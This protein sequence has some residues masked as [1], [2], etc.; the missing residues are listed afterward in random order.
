MRSVRIRDGLAL[1]LAAAVLTTRAAAAQEP[2][3]V[4]VEVAPEQVEVG[5]PV[6][7]RVTVL[8]PTWFPRPPEY[9]SLELANAVTRLDRSYP[10]S[11]RVG[12]N[13]SSA[14]SPRKAIMATWSRRM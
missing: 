14:V 8:T 5:R 11:E 2:P 9:P 12:G 7:L 6:E 3:L 4:R 13:S 1:L 10:T